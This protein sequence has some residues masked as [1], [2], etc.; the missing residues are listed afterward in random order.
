[1]SD[2][3]KCL[4]YSGLAF[5]IMVF[6]LVLYAFIITV[7]PNTHKTTLDDTIRMGLNSSMS[8]VSSQR[9]QSA[10]DASAFV[11]S[12]INDT[13]KDVGRPLTDEERRMLE[14]SLA[15]SFI[16]V[17]DSYIGNTDLPDGKVRELIV[18]TA[19]NSFNESV[20]D[21]DTSQIVPSKVYGAVAD[22]ATVY[23]RNAEQSV[24]VMREKAQEALA[25]VT[26]IV[27]VKVQ[28]ATEVTKQE[29][30]SIKQQFSDYS[31][32]CKDYVS[33]YGASERE[34]IK[35]R[36]EDAKMQLNASIEASHFTQDEKAKLRSAI[37][38]TAEKAK[39]AT[40]EVLNKANNALDRQVDAFN[41][42]LD[43]LVNHSNAYV[44]KNAGN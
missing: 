22:H 37:D 12:V 26:E 2:R 42:G 28:A 3:K 20:R 15:T 40:D 35:G 23:A 4:S 24:V 14:E 30:S 11:S 43:D 39:Q 16:A 13:M 21:V 25:G 41:E 18:E 5:L 7:F 34:D 9:I 19:L 8:D 33:A 44:E 10:S 1:M 29:I 27:G 31:V 17:Q 6:A 36:M 38:T 32:L